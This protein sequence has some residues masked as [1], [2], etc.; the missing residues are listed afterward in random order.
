MATAISEIT[1]ALGRRW[2]RMDGWEFGFLVLKLSL[3]QL[4]VSASN[5]ILAAAVL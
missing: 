4:G 1:I 3:A 2:L 5:W